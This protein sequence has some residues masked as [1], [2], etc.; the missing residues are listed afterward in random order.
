MKLYLPTC[1]VSSKNIKRQTK[2]DN[3]YNAILNAC[4]LPYLDY[5]FIIMMNTSTF[6]LQCIYI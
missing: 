4:K 2:H 1:S 3:E 6:N 5:S